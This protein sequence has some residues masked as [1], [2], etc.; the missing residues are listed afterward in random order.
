MSLNGGAQMSDISFKRFSGI[1]PKVP[2]SLLFK[3]AVSLS[4][5]LTSVL[6]K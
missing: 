4:I 2:F 5:S 3:A 1:L 6:E